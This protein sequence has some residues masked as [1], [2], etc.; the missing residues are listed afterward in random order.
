MPR[1]SHRF[2]SLD[3]GQ[4]ESPLAS[5][6]TKLRQGGVDIIDL[7]VSN[8]TTAGLTWP[9]GALGRGLTHPDVLQYTPDAKGLHS[10]REA[11]AEY[12]GD[13]G[14]P[15]D[16]DNLIL[17][18]GTSEAYAYL[19]K[20]LCDARDAVLVPVPGYPLFDFIALLEDVELHTYALRDPSWRIDFDA[21]SAA[22]TP[23]TKA[24]LSVQ[25]NNPT[26]N[27]LT[28]DEARRLAERAREADCAVIVDEV[29]CDF[30]FEGTVYTPVTSPDGLVFTLNGLSKILGLPQM[31]LAWIRIDG[32][33]DLVEAARE[34]LEIIA[35]TFL[36]PNTPVQLAAP[37]WLRERR[38]IQEKIKGRLATN[39]DIVRRVLADHPTIHWDE[40][41]GGWYVVLRFPSAIDDETL[42]LTFL[43]QACVHVHPGYMFGFDTG[44]VE[45]ISLLTPE[46]QFEAGL[47][48][49]ANFKLS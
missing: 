37:S 21:L 33:A 43:E 15:V 4:G 14:W 44:C 34:R 25:P 36:S 5:T 7:T 27:V 28:P 10:A 23:N 9:H 1:F 18:S 49:I 6:L 35:D 48:R 17:V 41:E 20:L 39:L 26:G 16:P 2:D 24:I 38:I 29:F 19:F 45:V 3:L 32:R 31:K 42:A 11:I 30:C 47:D 46:D 40:P 22:I 8:P 13:R 12:Y